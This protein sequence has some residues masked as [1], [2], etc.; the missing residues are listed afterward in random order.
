MAVLLRLFF[1]INEF[2]NIIW[3]AVENVAQLFK[4][5]KSY[6]FSFLQGVKRFVINPRFQKIILRYIFLFH[7]LPQ[8]IVADHKL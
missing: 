7:R 5:K 8:W 2:N 3:R 6:I 1:V 4:R